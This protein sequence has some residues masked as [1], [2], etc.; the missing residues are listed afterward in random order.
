VTVF[1]INLMTTARLVAYRSHKSASAFPR[2]GNR[3]PLL[4]KTTH[5]S[6]I[7]KQWRWRRSGPVTMKQTAAAVEERPRDEITTTETVE[8]EDWRHEQFV[9]TAKH[10]EK[11]RRL[12]GMTFTLADSDQ[13]SRTT[14]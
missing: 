10:T 13:R 8:V 7:V 6:P 9:F 5:T 3:L 2:L 14:L 1:L 4:F 11:A 12:D